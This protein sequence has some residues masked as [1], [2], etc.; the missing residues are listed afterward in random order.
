MNVTA[1]RAAALG[2]VWLGSM[3]CGWGDAT[4]GVDKE[5]EWLLAEKS[6]VT[7]ASL[8]PETR[9]MAAATVRVITRDEIRARGYRHLADLLRDLPGA[10]AIDHFYA[11]PKNQVVIRGI[12]GNNKFL[13]LLNGVRIGP[14]TGEPIV[15]VHENY[16]LYHARRV[17]ILYGPASAIYGADAFAGVINIITD[18]ADAPT[19][20]AHVDGGEFDTRRASLFASGRLAPWARLS[21]GAHGF[22]TDGADLADA[23]PDRFVLEDLVTF[24]GEVVARTEERPGYTG[25]HSAHSAWAQLDLGER[26]SLG[27]QHTVMRNRMNEGDLPNVTSYAP[28]IENIS[29]QLTLY[30]I[31]RAEHTPRVRSETLFGYTRY[32]QDPESRFNN[33]F[34]DFR[35]A[36]KYSLGERIFLEPR[37][38]LEHDVHITTA[39]LVLEYFHAI[40]HTPDLSQPY[41]PDRSAAEQNLYYPGSD[42]TLPV[43]IFE[44]TYHNLGGYVQCRSE[45]SDQW[46]TLL[47]LRGDYNSEY[48]GML[49][50]RVGAIYKPDNKQVWKLLYGHAYLA[51][52]PYLRYNHFGAFADRLPDGRYQSYFFRVPNPDL[53]PEQLRAIEL[54]YQFEPARHLRIGASAFY[55]Q[56][57]DLI[58]FAPT[59]EPISD[60]IPN[61][62]IDFTVQEQNIGELNTYGLELT[63]DHSL[64]VGATRIDWWISYTTLD[65]TLE[66]ERTG[67]D[68]PAPFTAHHNVKAGTTIRAGRLMVTPSLRWNSGQHG[69]VSE[70]DDPNR[71]RE[72]ESAVILDLYAELQSR[73]GDHAVFVRVLNALDAEHY[74]GGLSG[75]TTFYETPQDPRWISA[76]IRASF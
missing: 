9:E 2:A 22:E 21:V 10:D 32:E 66:N 61:A 17:E 41:D 8:L 48:E 69:F 37:L 62:V 25:A 40:P 73:S 58:L 20:R 54:S 67:L 19:A 33:I 39:G 59:P 5:L 44:R 63:A 12:G 60:F 70:P 57:Q 76:G 3:A 23:Y 31:H 28:D 16:P 15:P 56:V 72:A 30:G 35:D 55:N 11:E 4:N 64:Y 26:L 47:G 74:G 18:A 38:S 14:P 29:H 43:R 52:S 6:I 24:S 51:P 36:Y 27:F 49:N 1:R 45:W 7:T 34:S 68:I 50:P 53:D 46:A 71:G 13:I 42:E 75:L 65:G